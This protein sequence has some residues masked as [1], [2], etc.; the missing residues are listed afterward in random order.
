MVKKTVTA[1]TAESLGAHASS[2]P[3]VL[4]FTK[5]R[6]TGTGVDKCDPGR[7]PAM[8]RPRAFPFMYIQTVSSVVFG[9]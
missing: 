4:R 5:Q 6:V 1:G 7:C 3:Y 8:A 2:S 9:L